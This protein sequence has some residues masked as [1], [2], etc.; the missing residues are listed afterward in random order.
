M[1]VKVGTPGGLYFLIT[2]ALVAPFALVQ[3]NFINRGLH[4]Y[5]QTL[6]F[7]VYS[8]LLVLAN[9]LF[10]ALYYEEYMHLLST[11]SDFGYF[12]F[13]CMLRLHQSEQFLPVVRGEGSGIYYRP[14]RL[15]HSSQACARLNLRKHCWVFG[16]FLFQNANGSAEG[17]D[18]CSQL[19]LSSNEIFVLFLANSR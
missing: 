11:P 1:M 15:Q 13:G 18:S 7:P 17:V 6:F 2:L 10:G 14:K 16:H 4:L 12:V 9:T 8:S 5:P 19:S 3:I